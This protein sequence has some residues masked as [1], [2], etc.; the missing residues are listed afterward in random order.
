MTAAPEGPPAAAA[1]FQP[2]TPVVIGIVGGIAAG[3]SAVAERFAAHGLCH[4]DADRH[5]RAV[6]QRKDVLAEV[7]AAFGP[8]VVQGGT[9]DRAAMAALVFRDPSARTRLEAILHPRIRHDILAE[10]AAAQAAG[11]SALLDVPLLF[12][13]GLFEH[14]DHVVFVDAPDAVR[15]ARAKSRGWADGELARREQAQLPLADKR[16]RADFV[17]DN[18]GDRAT[19]A[20][21]VASLLRQLAERS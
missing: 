1:R 3:K 6:S 19:M 17:I 7:A 10:L 9:L 12:E 11:Q 18:G 13:N 5:A 20:A 14:C 4:V 2:R 15:Q 8:A 21:Q 16:A